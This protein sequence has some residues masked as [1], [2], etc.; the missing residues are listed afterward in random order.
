MNKVILLVLGMVLISG[1]VSSKEVELSNCIKTCLNDG[2]FE[3]RVY[4]DDW[5]KRY[6]EMII[7][8]YDAQDICYNE[9]KL[10]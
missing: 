5:D 1:C 8:K 10:R 4:Y 7:D 9:C 2:D 6:K 3:R